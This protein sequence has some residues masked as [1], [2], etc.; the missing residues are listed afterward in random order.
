MRLGRQG[1]ARLAIAAL[2]CL[3]A[4]AAAA[5][6]AEPV[7]EKYKVPTVGGAEINAGRSRCAPG[8]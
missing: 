8:A 6:A 5:P 7:F 4:L 1:I 3:L 2:V